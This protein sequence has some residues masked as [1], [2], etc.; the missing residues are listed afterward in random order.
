MT[1][2]YKNTFVKTRLTQKFWHGLHS[3]EEILQ[4]NIPDD[5][6]FFHQNKHKDTSGQQILNTHIHANMNSPFL[7]KQD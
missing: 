1:N 5:T 4:Y 6:P 7:S 2:L 3:I